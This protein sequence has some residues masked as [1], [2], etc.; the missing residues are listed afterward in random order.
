MNKNTPAAKTIVLTIDDV[1]I[2]FDV[3]RTV[4]DMQHA[5]CPTC[6]AMLGCQYWSADK[7]QW[8]HENG[9]GHKVMRLAVSAQQPAR[10]A[11]AA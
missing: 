5:Y 6:S 11:A 3:V 10:L 1:D 9:T 8:M 2:A 7:S 4:R